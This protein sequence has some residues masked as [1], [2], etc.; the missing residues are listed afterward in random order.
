MKNYLLCY[1]VCLYDG[2]VHGGHIFGKADQMSQKDIEDVL[3]F[4]LR[5]HNTG[6]GNTQSC[7]DSIVVRSFAWID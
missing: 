4:I 6:V 7:C 1:E 2:S 5:K 3:E